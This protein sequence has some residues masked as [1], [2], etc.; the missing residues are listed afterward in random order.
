MMEVAS[1][2]LGTEHG[3]SSEVRAYLYNENMNEQAEELITAFLLAQPG[4]WA[5]FYSLEGY[6][7]KI[8]SGELNALLFMKDDEPMGLAVIVFLQLGDKK[9][10][11]GDFLTCSHFFTFTQ[12][13]QEFEQ[14]AEKL[15][16]DYIDAFVPPAIAEYAVRKQGFSCAGLHIKKALGKARRH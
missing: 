1:M 10:C 16:M 13:Y 5:E 3:K 6:L 8:K 12:F 11:R 9:V 7:D 15:G 14:W 2:D 4:S